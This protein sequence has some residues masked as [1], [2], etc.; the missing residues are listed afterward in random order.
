MTERLGYCG[1][2]QGAL[3]VGFQGGRSLKMRQVGAGRFSGRVGT[4]AAKRCYDVAVA[5]ALLIV[6]TPVMLL[7]AV[8][9]R[10]DSAG[11]VFYRSRRVG[12]EGREFAMLKFRKMHRGAAGPL[13]TSRNDARLTRVGSFLVK[14][15]L[16]ELPQ[17]WNVIRGDM[18]LVGPRPEDPAFVALYPH[19]YSAVLKA[20]PGITG[21]SQ[22]AFAQENRILER[23]ELAGRYV[24]RLM[25]AKI[26]TD[27]LY[28]AR[29]STFL[30]TQI[31]AWTVAT[32][33]FGIDV[34]VD[35]Q[36]SRLSVRRRDDVG[37]HPTARRRSK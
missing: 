36:T 7:I 31:L 22:L 32:V 25:P 24:D 5:V 34:A 18:S 8:A 20:K 28:I 3:R 4:S 19:E 35:R 10:L 6:L 12:L 17:I 37:N 2:D 23:P 30:D 9:I 16:D 15:K 27:L 29:W 26:Q 33:L 14:T 13:L 21:L 1:S 11:P